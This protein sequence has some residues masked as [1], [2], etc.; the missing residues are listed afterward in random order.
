MSARK[1]HED[2]IDVSAELVTR[3]VAGQFPEWAELPVRPVT[4]SGTVNALFRLGPELVVRL[5]R[6]PWAAGEEVEEHR[7]LRRLA[8][9]LPV[10]VPAPVAVG[11]PAE[12]YPWTWSVLRWLPG[13]NPV[14]GQLDAADDLALD[15]AGFVRAFRSVRLPGGPAAYRGGP[16]AALDLPTRNAVAR[17]RG[18]IDTGAAIAVWEDGLRAPAWAGPPTWVHAD[19][20]PGNLLTVDGR[21]SAVIDFATVG[22]GD[23]AC[24]LIVAW[25]LL[26]SGA[27][28]VFRAA[29]DVDDATWRRAR[30]RALS[31]ALIALPYYRD[32]AP[33][34]AAEAR[35]TIGAVLADAASG[36][37]TGPTP[38]PDPAVDVRREPPAG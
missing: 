38:G 18:T 20:M 5:C 35:H 10:A 21:L 26:P 11:Q 4:R 13:T 3:L 6:V 15:L 24:D 17:L 16:L 1:M 14:P 29:V 28:D 19:L 27:R 37:T 36:P 25:N 22:V 8:P 23:P 32:R 9:Y 2:E 34:Y 31:I 33:E 12:G 30:G 7:W